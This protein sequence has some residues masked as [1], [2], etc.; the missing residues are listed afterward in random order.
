MKI[1]HLFVHKMN[2]INMWVQCVR[3]TLDIALCGSGLKWSILN[4]QMLELK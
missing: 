4:K 3:K 1:Q 2:N